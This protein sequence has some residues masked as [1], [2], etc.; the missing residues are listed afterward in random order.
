MNMFQNK[1]KKKFSKKYIIY[2]CF[3]TDWISYR[4]TIKKPKIN[5]YPGL[6]IIKK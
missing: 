3:F 2:N 5:K 6:N 4:N 1:S